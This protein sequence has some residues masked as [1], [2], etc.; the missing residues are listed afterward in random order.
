[1]DGLIKL[2]DAATGKLI[3]EFEGHAG[4]VHTVAYSPDG[5]RLLSGGADKTAV[6]W[7]IESGKAVQ[8]LQGHA[9]V[10]TCAAFLPGGRQAV[11]SSYD[12]TLRLWNVRR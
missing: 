2:H 11:T 6:V 10:I 7:D 12:K 4:G 5:R 1:M 8:R 3:K 9:E